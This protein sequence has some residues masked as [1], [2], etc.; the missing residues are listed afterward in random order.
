LFKDD[1]NK[2]TKWD[3]DRGGTADVEEQIVKN[4]YLNAQMTEYA[5]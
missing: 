5:D 1:T 2:S 3:D 4:T